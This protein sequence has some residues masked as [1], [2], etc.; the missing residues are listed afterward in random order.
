[1]SE[2]VKTYEKELHEAEMQLKEYQIENDSLKKELQE[3]KDSIQVKEFTM[4]VEKVNSYLD[5]K[6]EDGILVPADKEKYFTLSV[7]EDAKAISGFETVKDILDSKEKVKEFSGK[8]EVV[9]I[10]EVTNP[11]DPAA[12]SE[13][14]DK[15]AKEYM[16]ENNIDDYREALKETEIKEVS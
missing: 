11:N 13:A 15:R 9:E 2:E 5:K 12:L 3:T 7:D 8:S 6:I 16:K 14:H 4:E 10:P 1:M